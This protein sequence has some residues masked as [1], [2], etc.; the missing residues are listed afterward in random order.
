MIA[1]CLSRQVALP[2]TPS[3]HP[4]AAMAVQTAA[5]EQLR[6]ILDSGEPPQKKMMMEQQRIMQH[7]L[8]QNLLAMAS[9]LPLNIKLNN[10]GKNSLLRFECMLFGWCC[11][12][13]FVISS[14][15]FPVKTS[16]SKV[17]NFTM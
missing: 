11:M 2:M 3:S 7:A 8:Q 5:L 10:R 4:A 12:C 14:F 16:L 15:H 9:Q 6:E 1:S 13:V 17:F